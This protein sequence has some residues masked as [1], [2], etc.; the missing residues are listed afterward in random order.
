MS[1]SASKTLAIAPSQTMRGHTERVYDAVHLP[2]GRRIITCSADGSLRLWDLK[3]S[4]Q[5]GEDWRDENHE[6]RSMSLSPNGGVVASGCNDGKL[7]LWDVETR[8]V[9]WK[10][11]GHTKVVWAL[12]WSADGERVTSGSWD[13]TA[14]V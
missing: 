8:K 12:C 9:I 3:N 11:T 4:T 6:V 5:I 10:L 13:G 14:R 1:S 7:R 2:D